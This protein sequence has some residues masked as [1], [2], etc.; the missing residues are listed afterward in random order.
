MAQ[1]KRAGRFAELVQLA[2]NETPVAE[3]TS[4]YAARPDLFLCLLRP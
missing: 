3:A 4:W 1:P 2:E